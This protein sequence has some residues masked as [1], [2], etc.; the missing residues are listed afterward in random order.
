MANGA[1]S[2]V[3]VDTAEVRVTRWHLGPGTATGHHRHAFDYVIVPLMDGVVT[4]VSAD[5]RGD[6]VFRAGESYFRKAGVE[7]DVRNETKSDIAFVEIE[8]KR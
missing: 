6:G 8:I 2:T 1:S 7:H 4:V 3:Q 5:G